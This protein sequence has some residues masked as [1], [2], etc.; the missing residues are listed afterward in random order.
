MIDIQVDVN[1]A[2]VLGQGLFPFAVGSSKRRVKEKRQKSKRGKKKKNEKT[3]LKPEE[4]KSTAEATS[5][6]ANDVTESEVEK[7]QLVEE[8]QPRME[9]LEDPGCQAHPSTLISRSFPLRF[10]NLN[11][12]FP[13]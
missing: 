3:T 9:L 8:M 10:L 4:T 2:G 11:T 7:L 6:T 1:A 12:R 13:D 5:V